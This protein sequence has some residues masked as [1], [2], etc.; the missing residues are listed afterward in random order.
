MCVLVTVYMIVSLRTNVVF[1]LI[2]I[3]LIPTFALLA[4]FFFNISEEKFPPY[5]ALHA[6]G[7]LAFVVSMLGWYIFL[8]ILLASVDFPFS[9]PGKQK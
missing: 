2:F 3:L 4:F 8:A 7:A 5:N 6:A 1:L 9:L